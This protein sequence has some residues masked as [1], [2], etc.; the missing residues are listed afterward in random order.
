MSCLTLEKINSKYK[1]RERNRAEIFISRWNN[2][3]KLWEI[4]IFGKCIRKN[5]RFLDIT[6]YSFDIFLILP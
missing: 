6:K 2:Y 1:E 4:K 3:Y 5:K